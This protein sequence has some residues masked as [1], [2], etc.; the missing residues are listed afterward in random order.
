LKLAATE[1]GHHDTCADGRVQAVL[2]RDS[3]GDGKRHGKRQSHDPDHGAREDI[4]T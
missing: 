1:Y 3:Y 4:G 2:R